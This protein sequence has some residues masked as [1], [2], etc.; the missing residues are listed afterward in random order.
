MLGVAIDI[1]YRVINTIRE[2]FVTRRTERDADGLLAGSPA[3]PQFKLIPRLSD[4]H[5]QTPDCIAAGFACL[6]QEI[7]VGRIIDEIVSAANTV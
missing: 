2:K 3:S 7:R 4:K 1:I 5:F 6:A